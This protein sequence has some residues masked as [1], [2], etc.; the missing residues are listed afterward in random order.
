MDYEKSFTS[1]IREARNKNEYGVIG[2]SNSQ[3][4]MAMKGRDSYIVVK[5]RCD[6]RSFNCSLDGM[7][8]DIAERI[9][10]GKLTN[11]EKYS[12]SVR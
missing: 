3:M 11:T 10:E 2:L 5:V 7:Y 9:A 1:Y 6:R 8:P 12:F 4:Q